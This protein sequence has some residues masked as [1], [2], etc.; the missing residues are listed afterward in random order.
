MLWTVF[1]SAAAAVGLAVVAAVGKLL[2]YLLACVR[3]K[4]QFLS[5][6]IPGPPLDAKI[7]GKHAGNGDA[8]MQDTAQSSLAGV[9]T[10]GDDMRSS[11][12]PLCT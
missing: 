8:C 3:A 10:A 11:M 1:L 2:L 7:I 12:M 4:R 5:S 9:C 6:P